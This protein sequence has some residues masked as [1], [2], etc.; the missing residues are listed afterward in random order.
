VTPLKLELSGFTCFKGRTELEFAGLGLFAIAG[1][2]GAGK[3]TLLDAIT[4]AIYGQTPRLGKQ[5]LEALI[6][7]GEAQ[8]YVTLDFA[9]A[10]GSYRVTR[11]ADRKP[12]G[13]QGFDHRRAT[14]NVMFGRRDRARLSSTL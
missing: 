14:P 3:T 8:L 5:G 9:T 2:T 12:S 6:S 7:P 1:P 10:Q 4:Y 11:T 13:K